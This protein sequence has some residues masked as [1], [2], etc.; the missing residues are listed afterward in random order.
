F[1]NNKNFKKIFIYRDPRDQVVSLA[2]FML[3]YPDTDY[4]NK[5]SLIPFDDLIMDIISEG[6]T[7]NGLPPTKNVATLY[8]SYLP[9][10]NTSGVLC[11]RFEDL[12]GPK[13]GNSQKV[14]FETIRKIADQLEIQLSEER[15]EEIANNL[16]GNTWTFREGKIGAWKKYFKSEHIT[17]F[18]KIA[19]KLLINLGY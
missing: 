9:W 11:I 2:F 18:K 1:L 15:L 8:D 17:A 14:Q 5:A 4:W 7:F 19:G 6:S 12:I 10:L 13:G 16:F 3:R